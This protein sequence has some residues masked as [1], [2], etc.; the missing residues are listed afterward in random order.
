MSV[1][2]L[3]INPV[4]RPPGPQSWP[5]LREA[6]LREEERLATVRQTVASQTSVCED[7]LIASTPEDSTVPSD[8][9]GRLPVSVPHGPS[10]RDSPTG[11]DAGA[12][13]AG[14]VRVE[15]RQPPI[16]QS[17]DGGVLGSEQAMREACACVIDGLTAACDVSGL[18][19]A[20]AAFLE[21]THQRFARIAGLAPRSPLRLLSDHRR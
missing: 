19:E 12:V 3:R 17:H 20:D 7:A 10:H 16:M 8:G 2:P 18:S 21:R 6:T 15:Q 4:D 5:V 9:R 11:G 13:V 14:E 1:D